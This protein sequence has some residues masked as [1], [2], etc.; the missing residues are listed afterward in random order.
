MTTVDPF[1]V[2]TNLGMTPLFARRMLSDG[3]INFPKA[4]TDKD[5]KAIMSQSYNVRKVTLSHC[6]QITDKAL[7]AIAL[8]A[9][10][11]LTSIVLQT[12]PGVTDNGVA[13]IARRCE[14]LTHLILGSCPRLSNNTVFSFA[15]NHNSL[16]SV[17]ITDCGG[18][19]DSA[20]TA[21]AEAKPW[22]SVVILSGNF[23]DR[24]VQSL[25]D[26]CLSLEKIVI[27]FPCV[28]PE[29]I[30][31]LVGR[32]LYLKDLFTTELLVQAKFERSIGKRKT[33]EP[34]PEGWWLDDGTGPRCK[35]PMN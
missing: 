4:I 6:R 27:A 16:T 23:T 18:I 26:N 25:A 8:H 5:V 33:P 9:N 14:N 15:D 22:M 17:Q 1:T 34:L 29:T 7:N 12:L 35:G 11:T 10:E 20:I 3:N 24:T 32:C 31:H 2:L 19:D 21:L 13:S 28:S 30:P